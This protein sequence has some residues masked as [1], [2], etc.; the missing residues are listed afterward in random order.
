MSDLSSKLQDK[1]SFLSD[2]LCPCKCKSE[3]FLCLAVNNADAP[4]RCTVFILWLGVPVGYPTCESQCMSPAAH[5]QH[6]QWP[7][8]EWAAHC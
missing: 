2:Y 5:H 4:G 6:P 8:S 7:R 1:F 3:V